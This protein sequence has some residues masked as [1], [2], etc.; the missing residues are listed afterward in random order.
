[1]TMAEAISA[2]VGIVVLWRGRTKPPVG[3]TK[4]IATK[5]DRL[6][7]HSPCIHRGGA[8]YPSPLVALRP[9]SL[10][11]PACMGSWLSHNSVVHRLGSGPLT[12]NDQFLFRKQP[13]AAHS[14]KSQTPCLHAAASQ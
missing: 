4:S 3:P 10:L 8:R 2:G 11:N 9:R 14:V 7:R 6:A 12:R 13:N 5:F 1:M